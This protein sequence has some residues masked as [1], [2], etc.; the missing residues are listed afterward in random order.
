MGRSSKIDCRL[1][2]VITRVRSA[3]S[4]S[5][6]ILTQATTPFPVYPVRARFTEL[7]RGGLLMCPNHRSSRLSGEVTPRPEA[8]R[9]WPCCGICEAWSPRPPPGEASSRQPASGAWFFPSSP[10]PH[11]LRWGPGHAQRIYGERGSRLARLASPQTVPVVSSL[12]IDPRYGLRVCSHQ[13]Q[14]AL[15]DTWT[16]PPAWSASPAD[17]DIHFSDFPEIYI[18]LVHVIR[19]DPALNKF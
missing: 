9:I 18:G 5:W 10:S 15:G 1:Y 11:D 7:V 12:P 17:T 3:P 4:P 14:T 8:P 13:S 16:F 6:G 19:R 2:R